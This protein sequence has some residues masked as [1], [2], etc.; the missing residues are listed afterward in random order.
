MQGHDII[1]IGFSAGGIE[2]LLQLVA[3]LPSDLPAAVFVVHHFP[4]H[5]VSALPNILARVSELPVRNARDRDAVA[6]GHIYVGRPDRHLLLMPGLVRLTRGPREHGNRPALDPLFRSAAR[7]YGSRVIGV[8]LSGTLDDGT[9]GL[10]AIKS[11]GGLAVVEDP[12]QA[13]YPGMPKSAVDHVE[14]DY[15]ASAAELGGLLTRLT[16]EPA[17]PPASVAPGDLDPELDPDQPEPAV[18]GTAALRRS[19]LPGIPST[20]TCPECGGLLF[21]EEEADLLHFRCHVGHAYSEETLMSVQAHALE[22]AL[23]AA[24]RALEE[25]AELGRRLAERAQARGW[26]TSAKR[27]EH[28]AR[29]AEKGSSMI[30]DTLLNGPVRQALEAPV[31]EDEPEAERR[32]AAVRSGGPHGG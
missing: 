11:A 5:S 4:A 21:E 23:W 9:V 30:R 14:V 16:R 2:P 22:S 10:H 3:D 28:A 8:V 26:N 24:V 25:K 1:V 20:L 32:A 19:T 17:L 15:V 29:D 27:F 7:S 6:T 12:E 18:V 13:A 31:E